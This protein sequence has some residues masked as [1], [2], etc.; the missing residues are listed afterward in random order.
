MGQSSDENIQHEY[1][2]RDFSFGKLLSSQ[3]NKKKA[4]GKLRFM[5]GNAPPPPL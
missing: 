5:N 3:D 2:K 1:F 4:I